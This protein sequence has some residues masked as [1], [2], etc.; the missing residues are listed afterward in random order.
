M[1][2]Y[3][4]YAALRHALLDPSLA[5]PMGPLAFHV[6]RPASRRYHK[7][8]P[9]TRVRIPCTHSQMQKPISGVTQHEHVDSSHTPVRFS[10]QNPAL[11]TVR[12]RI[13]AGC[14]TACY[15]G[16]FLG[17][18]SMP[19]LMA[20]YCLILGTKYVPTPPP[21]LGRATMR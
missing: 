14:H 6:P 1:K 19:I 18:D 9:R 12:D 20:S 4:R 10:P 21:G 5:E 16:L 8:A 15:L 17:P 11:Q 3:T 7:Q 13:K 2:G